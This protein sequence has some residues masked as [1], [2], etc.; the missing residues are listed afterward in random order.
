MDRAALLL[1]LWRGGGGGKGALRG[2]KRIS[3]QSLHTHRLIQWLHAL[4]GTC[5]TRRLEL[6][7]VTT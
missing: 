4:L 2:F 6:Q 3:L 5:S 7:V 1:F